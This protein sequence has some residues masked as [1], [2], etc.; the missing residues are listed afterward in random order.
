MHTQVEQLVDER[1]PIEGHL[2][3][4]FPSRPQQRPYVDPRAEFLGQLSAQR[5]LRCLS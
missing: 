5:I 4:S 2:D 3:V 1:D